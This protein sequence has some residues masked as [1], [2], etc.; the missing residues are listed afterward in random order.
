MPYTRLKAANDGGVRA[1]LLAFYDR[2]P[3]EELTIGDIAVKTGK[4]RITVAKAL[5]VMR[6]KGEIESVHVV[7][8][9]SGKR[10]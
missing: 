1:F 10:Q 6:D 8:L 3:A 9:P 4:S 5:Q 2:N 7:R